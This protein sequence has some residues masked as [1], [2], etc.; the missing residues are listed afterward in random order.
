MTGTVAFLIPHEEGCMDTATGAT[1]Q[2]VE[3]VKGSV[4]HVM[5]NLTGATQP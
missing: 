3:S 1:Y 2:S 4:D 5:F